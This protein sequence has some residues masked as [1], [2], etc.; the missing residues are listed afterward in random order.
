MF[1][2]LD[3]ES[4]AVLFPKDWADG[5]KQI[6]LNIYG[7]RCIKDEKTFEIFGFSYPNEVLLIISY[8]GLDK[9]ET[10]VT[11]FLSSDLTLKT[12]T[13]KIMDT[14]FDSAGVFFDSY[15]ATEESEDE[16][17]DD[18][19]LD[20]Q[21]AEFGSD[22]IFYMVTRENV[23]LTMEANLILGDLADDE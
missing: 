7:E 2:R 11:L 15:F 23:M 22:K 18:Y 5:L 4:K 6:L 20:W 1:S 3:H 19:V 8:V 14:M 13:D 9:F 10:P 21:D 16:I 17:W 12:A